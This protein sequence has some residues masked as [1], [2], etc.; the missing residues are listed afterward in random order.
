[1]LLIDADLPGL[2]SLG[3]IK[4]LESE[5]ILRETAVIVLASASVNADATQILRM[6]AADVI[7]KPVDLPVLVDRVRR[8]L[9][10]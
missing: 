6:G 4:Q 1:V 9:R 10:S 3:F 2:D 8:E 5:G 7:A